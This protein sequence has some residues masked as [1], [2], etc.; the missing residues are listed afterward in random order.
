VVGIA[1]HGRTIELAQELEAFGRLRPALRVVA[2]ADDPVDVMRGEIGKHRSECD[3]VP[4]H[5]G[6]QRDAH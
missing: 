5:V 3:T 6:E 4:M 2:E 1:H